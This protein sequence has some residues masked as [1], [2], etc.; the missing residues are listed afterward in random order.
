MAAALAVIASTVGRLWIIAGLV[1]G[2]GVGAQAQQFSSSAVQTQLIELY[3]SEGCSSCPPADQWLSR[4]KTD[5]ALWRRVIPLAFHVDY[6]DYIG[7]PDRFADPAYVERQRRYKQQNTLRAVYTP[8]FLV[9]GREW[10][11]WWAN[12]QPPRSMQRPGVL[13]ISVNGEQF[14]AAFDAAQPMVEGHILNVA[15]VGFDLTTEVKAGENSGEVLSHDFVVLALEAHHSDQWQWR[16]QLP[17]V[18]PGFNATGLGLVAWVSAAS[19]QLP[20]QAV[21]GLLR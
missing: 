16:G 13:T 11:G 7:W 17:A 3:T 12:R 19:S 8:G 9:D 4:F 10:K 21:G 6:W 5:P 18:A 2:A 15:I 20:I 1:L 14:E